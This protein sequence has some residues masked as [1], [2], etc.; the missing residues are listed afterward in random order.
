L[1]VHSASENL[2]NDHT[3]WNAILFIEGEYMMCDTDHSASREFNM[4]N[5]GAVMEEVS[6]SR[7]IEEEDRSLKLLWYH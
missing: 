1:K 4:P 7:G 3:T 2:Y 5:L 6:L